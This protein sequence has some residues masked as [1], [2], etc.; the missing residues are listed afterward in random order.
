MYVTLVFLVKLIRMW[1]IGQC[2]AQYFTNKIRF[3]VELF[4]CETPL[5]QGFVIFCFLVENSVDIEE[6][7]S[8]NRIHR[9]QMIKT[10]PKNGDSATATYRALRVDNSFH[11]SPTT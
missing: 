2:I 11:N 1:S 4:S 6:N 3:L 7:R 8:L 5:V 10:Y 9:I